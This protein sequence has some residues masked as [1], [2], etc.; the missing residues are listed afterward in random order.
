MPKFRHTY[1]YAR[2]FPALG[3]VQPDEIV[4]A[5]ENPDGNFFDEVEEP[6][7]ERVTKPK[8]EED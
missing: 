4:T 1:P 8:S 2:V 7:A 3:E 6:K 5:K